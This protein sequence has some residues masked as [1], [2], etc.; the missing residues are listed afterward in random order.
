VERFTPR[1]FVVVALLVFPIAFVVAL[2]CF[3]W[4]FFLVP[5]VFG[6]ASVLP[7]LSAFRT[8]VRDP[9][10]TLLFY[11]LAALSAIAGVGM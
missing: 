6:I 3:P 10:T 7:S 5:N 4:W 1:I 2:G 9:P 8:D 11:V